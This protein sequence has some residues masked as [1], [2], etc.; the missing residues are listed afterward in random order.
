MRVAIAV[1]DEVDVLDVG[2]PYEAFLTASRLAVRAGAPPPF[3]VITVGSGPVRAYGGLTLVPQFTHDSVGDLDLLVVPGAVDIDGV[4]AD[5]RLMS[6]LRT[7]AARAGTVASVCTGA[8]L[9]A[10]LGL[11]PPRWTTHWEDVTA[12]GPAV[13]A[14]GDPSVRW[15]DA[16]AVIT[17][18]GLSSGIAMALHLVRRFADADL[19]ERTAVQ[20]D[21]DW[22][23]Q[24]ARPE[25]VR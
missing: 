2:G 16:G 20:L 5:Q 17:S 25:A 19:A 10:D 18:G 3:E 6:E 22:D 23:P 15:V 12:L 8:F 7:L 13:G 11:L 4:R 24:G 14:A 1:F 9:L 21:Y